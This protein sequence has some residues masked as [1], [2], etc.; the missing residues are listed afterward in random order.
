MWLRIFFYL[1]IILI[2]LVFIHNFRATKFQSVLI[3]GYLANFIHTKPISMSLVAI[4]NGFLF[5][6]MIFQMTG[7]RILVIVLLLILMVLS[8]IAAMVMIKD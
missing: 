8:I 4:S 7:L 1:S 6:I 3:L 5:L 2:L